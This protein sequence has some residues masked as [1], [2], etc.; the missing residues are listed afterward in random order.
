[1]MRTLQIFRITVCVCMASLM[2]EAYSATAFRYVKSGGS[3]TKTGADWANASDNIQG[4]IDEV[5]TGGGGEVW[6]AGG[7]YIISTTLKMKE[8]VNVRGG[9]AGSETSIEGRQKNSLSPWDFTNATVLNANYSG[10]LRTRVLEQ[11]NSFT[12]E[13]VYDGLTITGGGGYYDNSNNNYGCGAYIRGNGKLCNSIV[14]DN[15]YI[16]G[17]A[18]GC[19]GGGVYNYGGII[20][21]CLVTGNKL[22][23]QAY[24]PVQ[25]IEGGGIYNT[26]GGIVDGCTVT[27]NEIRNENTA[28]GSNLY[29]GGIYNANGIIRLCRNVSGNKVSASNA[30]T[31]TYGG[32]IA[33][34][35]VYSKCVSETYCPLNI[36]TDC[37]VENNEV[38]NAGEGGGIYKGRVSRC[39]IQGN[40]A[41]KGGGLSYSIA[42][43]CLIRKN[44]A[45][46]VG[47]GVY[48]GATYSDSD[49]PGEIINC[50]VVQNKA[51]NGQGGGTA[52]CGEIY[53]NRVTAVNCIIWDNTAKATFGTN[54]AQCLYTTLSHSAIQYTVTPGYPS[55]IIL[56]MSNEDSESD[57]YLAPRF[58]K[59]VGSAGEELDFRLQPGSPCIGMGDIN[60]LKQYEVKYDTNV[61]NLDL[62]WFPRCYGRRMDAGAYELKKDWIIDVIGCMDRNAKS[63][64]PMATINN[65]EACVYELVNNKLCGCDDPAALNYNPAVTDYD[66]S[67]VYAPE[68]STFNNGTGDEETT[69]VVGTNP[70][71]NCELDIPSLIT[72]AYIAGVDVSAEDVATVE[73]VIKQMNGD[74][75]KYWVDY[76]IN[77]DESGLFL[78]YLSIICKEGLKSTAGADITAY[79]FSDTYY[80]DLG[81][82]I[83]RV[84]GEPGKL[85]VY[86]NPV[87][88]LLQIVGCGV[89][90]KI[91]MADILGRNVILPPATYQ[92]ESATIDVSA[93]PAGIY[94]VKTIGAGKVESATIVKK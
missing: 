23:T 78:F 53:Y 76:I 85:T 5:S 32:G 41:G 15:L 65:E 90:D 66:G 12:V 81:S 33:C 73:W 82:G 77:A 16:A 69:G 91:E 67:C 61:M 57:T 25:T 13:T 10:D 46:D 70:L 62:S 30:N 86:P 17:N 35:G 40:K 9:F 11:P 56:C 19:C 64:N 4:M 48:S 54:D 52:G 47:G 83:S 42:D 6:I 8:G 34:A 89:G 29:G 1:M 28:G 84:K 31:N 63:Y 51:T 49:R 26:N 14:K 27:N 94:V 7:T 50:T 21:D 87:K 71:E 74:E 36:V 2:T 68:E 22:S 43:N 93:L 60:V 39:I 3:G 92:N 24:N 44:T 18:A 59:P 72:L 58:V 55:N 37:I 88:D 20:L 38:S 75:I 45:N 80:L 79:T